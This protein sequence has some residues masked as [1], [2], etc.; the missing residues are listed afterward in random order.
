MLFQECDKAINR[1]ELNYERVWDLLG[2]KNDERK[3]AQKVI[4]S[5][6]SCSLDLRNNDH[7]KT[8]GQLEILATTPQNLTVAFDPKLDYGKRVQFSGGKPVV[9]KLIERDLLIRTERLVDGNF[10]PV[11]SLN[12]K[13]LYELGS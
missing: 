1:E 9:E 12:A 5:Y 10:R 2:L 8:L 6:N 4:N 3:A 13:K 7:L 11:Y